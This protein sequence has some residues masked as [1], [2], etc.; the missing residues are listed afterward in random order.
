MTH[1]LEVDDD[2]FLLRSLERPNATSTLRLNY[3]PNQEKPVE[4]SIQ[5]GVYLGCETHVDS[6]FLTILYQDKVGGL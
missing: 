2:Q 1:C 6:G 4:I 3:Y 5:D